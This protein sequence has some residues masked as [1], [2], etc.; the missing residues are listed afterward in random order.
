[1]EEKTEIRKTEIRKEK[2]P[3]CGAELLPDVMDAVVYEYHYDGNCQNDNFS[4]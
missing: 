3:Y 2:C 4:V 1:M